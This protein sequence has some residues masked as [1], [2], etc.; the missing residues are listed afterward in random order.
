MPVSHKRKSMKKSAKAHK[1]HKLSKRSKNF[2]KNKKTRSMRKMRGGYPNNNGN[3]FPMVPSNS[4]DDKQNMIDCLLRYSNK[5]TMENYFNSMREDN[6]EIQKFTMSSEHKFFIYNC[7]VNNKNFM[8]LIKISKDF[9]KG[10]KVNDKISKYKNTDNIDGYVQDYIADKDWI[11]LYVTPE[12]QAYINRGY[13]N[14]NN[15]PNLN[16]GTTNF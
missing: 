13:K 10:C 1:S 8:L 5:D 4:G 11:T 12:H 6:S 15:N 2:R 14:E 9:V 16:Y 7:N 3:G